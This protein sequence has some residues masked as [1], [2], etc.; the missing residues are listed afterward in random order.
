M[1]A[2]AIYEGFV[3]HHR[4]E[5]EHEFRY[6]LFMAYLDL[7]ELPWVL[8]PF[9]G[10]SARRPALAW[11]RRADFLG[12]PERPL[13]DCVR[14]AV[15]E[16]TGE[17]PEGPIRMLGNL[18]HLGHAFNPV[19]FYYCFDAAGAQVRSVLAEVTNTPWGERH[20]YLLGGSNGGSGVIRGELDKDFHVSPLMGMDHRYDW[21]TTTPGDQVV[22]H[23]DSSSAGRPSFD[24]TLSLQRRELR[25]G[26]DAR[27]P[28]ALSGDQRPR[29][30]GYLLAGLPAE[31][32]GRGV[33]SPSGARMSERLRDRMARRAC[34]ALLERIGEGRVCV[35]ESGSEREFGC[36]SA[37]GLS[38]AVHVRDP[39]AWSLL[40]R[41][42]S[43]L[44]R[45][46]VEGH[47]QTD[48]LVGLIR[49]IARNMSGIDRLRRRWHPVLG[50]LQKVARLVP[51]NTR[52]GARSNIAAHYDLGNDLFATFLDE[53]LVYSSAFFPNAGASLDEA[54]H[55][56]LE[57]ICTRLELDTDDHLLEIG[58]GWGGLAIH[59]ARE[60]G[61]RVTT[62]TIS[63]EQADYARRK[64]SDLGLEGRVTVLESDYR[65]LTGSFDKLVSIEMV[66]AVGWQYFDTFF[67]RCSDLLRPGG[68]MLLQAIVITD[69]SYEAEKAS[70]SFANTAVFPGGCLPSERVIDEIVARE[71][72]LV[73]TW[74]D[75][76]TEHYSRTL[77]L[78]RERFVAAAPMLAAR[79]YDERF[80]RLWAFYLAFSEAGFRERR[81]RDLQL[82]FAKPGGRA[83]CRRC[84][85]HPDRERVTLHHVRRGEG[86]ALV[87]IH[88]LGGT[89]VNWDPVIDLLAAERDVIAV[90]MPGFGGSD[91]LPDGTPHSAV[92]MGH[93]I[94]RHLSSLGIERPHIAGNSLG[95]WVA[96]EMAADG[97]AASVC[98]ISPAGLWRKPLGQRTFDTRTRGK[99]LRPLVL[100]ALRTRRGRR[101]L[102]RTTIARPDLMS[103]AEAVRWVSAWL[104]APGYEDANLMMRTL[105]FERVADVHVPV[106]VAWGMEDRLVRAP[107]LE[108]M[109]PQTRFF[110]VPGWGHTP[111]RDDPEGVTRLLLEASAESV[112]AA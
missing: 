55:A 91:P 102:M 99:Q 37:D 83:D 14:D 101:A 96:F 105:T 92:N 33:P 103:G 79:G 32:E 8:D 6:P 3:Q 65:D 106:T 36:A 30:G 109:P 16:R 18:R 24:A 98:A 17:A 20:V 27:H 59:A 54:Q 49:L 12:D 43:G 80:R 19:T 2:S 111:T 64:V 26:D 23:I 48:D 53:Q 4:R 38:A 45:G 46:Y 87:L 31:A 62:T 15:A 61:C 112:R 73:S 78:W 100:A 60:H 89:L 10:W 94:T 34:C 56:K 52:G 58:T 51:R 28:H 25:P 76:I 82:L 41:G 93:A 97:N 108:R 44:A 75:D 5:P 57:R 13:A 29:A 84:R 70:R 40:L 50:R 88:G 77:Q 66:E 107:R 22:V 72:D 67:R 71:T 81:I 9:P 69:E 90:D 39:R 7:D 63:R 42:S 11:F 95:A 1:T 104:D 74:R 86:P 21:R 68:A 85:A 47:W 110:E 35:A